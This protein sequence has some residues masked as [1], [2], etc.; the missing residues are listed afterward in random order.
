M[1]VGRLPNNKLRAARYSLYEANIVP[2]YALPACDS[3][4]VWA[5]AYG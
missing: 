2:F 3:R 5:G 4:G 1:R